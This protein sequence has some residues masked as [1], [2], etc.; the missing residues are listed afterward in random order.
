MQL[1]S[2]Q[3]K[4]KHKKSKLVGRGA[5]RGMYSGKG[6]KGQKARAGRK[7]RPEMRDIIKKIHKKRGYQF[8]SIYKKPATI[9]VGMLQDFPEGTVISSK[10]LAQKKLIHH[11]GGKA[12]IVKILGNGDLT[13]KLI[14]SGLTFSKE[15][16]VKIEKSGGEIK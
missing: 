8:A 6:R 7:M 13:K 2:I 4:T 11:T 5:T 16:R 12:P 10:F 9:N 15:A 14:F 1:H 3:R